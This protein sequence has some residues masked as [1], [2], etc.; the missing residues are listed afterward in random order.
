M[1][2]EAAY[3]ING[4]WIHSYVTKEWGS[5]KESQ[6]DRAEIDASEIVEDDQFAF[7]AKPY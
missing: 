2:N 1:A 4:A 6:A 5:N 3:K 7:D